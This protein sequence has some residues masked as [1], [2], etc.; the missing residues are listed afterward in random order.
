MTH[1]AAAVVS[2]GAALGLFCSVG[3]MGRQKREL[4]GSR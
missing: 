3:G 1:V 2:K 4:N